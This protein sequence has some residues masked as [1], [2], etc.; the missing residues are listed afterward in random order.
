MRYR[1]RVLVTGAG[2]F[3][4]GHL[5]PYLYEKGYEIWAAFHRRRRPFPFPVHWLQA[6]LTVPRQGWEAVRRSRPQT[7]F[8]LAGQSVPGD[9]WANPGETFKVNTAASLF[10]FEG[11]VRYAPETRI[12]L[13]SSGHVYGRTFFAQSRVREESL[14]EPVSPYGAAKLLMEAA[15]WN[16]SKE[17]GLD[18]VIIRPFN[19]VGKGQSPRFVF[20]DFCHQTARIEKAGRPGVLNVGNLEVVRDFVHVEDAVRAYELLARRGKSG[21]AYNLGSGRGIRLKQIVDF[22]KE[23][24]RVPLRIQLTASRIQRHEIRRAIADTSKLRRLGWSTQRTPWQA[25]KEILEE[26]RENV[27]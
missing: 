2:G 6:D 16:F 24:C 13:A 20:S 7:I 23:E 19:Q 12:V 18:A 27:K 17:H 5:I 9:S 25:L 4:A 11:V 10:L 21:E 1:K 15:A 8:H 22:L 26:W 3:V 14:T